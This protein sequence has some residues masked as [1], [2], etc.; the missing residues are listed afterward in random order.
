MIEHMEL[1][2]TE[3]E[4]FREAFG[5]S[6]EQSR[7][8]L[9]RSWQIEEQGVGE[10]EQIIDFLEREEGAWGVQDSQ[11]VFDNQ[12]QLD[13][14][15]SYFANIDMLIAEQMELQKVQSETRRRKLD[16]L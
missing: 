7:N 14:Y 11:F 3:R 13:Q 6:S 5:N 16:G 15:N 4:V 2:E 12:Q 9:V 8:V 1:P 10:I